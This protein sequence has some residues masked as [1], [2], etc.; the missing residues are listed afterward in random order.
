MTA[1]TCLTKRSI[2][3]RSLYVGMTM[4]IG[5]WGFVDKGFTGEYTKP[6]PFRTGYWLDRASIDWGPSELG[7]FTHPRE[8][9]GNPSSL[10]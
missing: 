2:V 8:T 4:E 10:F 5:V 6:R 3:P 9:V 1:D 7:K